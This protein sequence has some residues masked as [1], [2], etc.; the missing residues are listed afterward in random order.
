VQYAPADGPGQVD[1]VLGNDSGGLDDLIAGGVEGDGEAAAVEVHA[2]GGFD[3][4][5]DGDARWLG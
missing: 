3:R 4:V 1:D 5:G 2:A